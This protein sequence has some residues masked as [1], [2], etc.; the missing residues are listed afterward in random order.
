LRDAA[1]DHGVTAEQ[2][3]D[4]RSRLSA[5]AAH[6]GALLRDPEAYAAGQEPPR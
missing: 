4:V 5:T 3:K 1:R 6:V 2:L